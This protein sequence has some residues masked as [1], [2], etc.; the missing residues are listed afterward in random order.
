L[1]KISDRLR[2]HNVIQTVSATPVLGL[3][4]N[5]RTDCAEIAFVTEE[6]C[7]LLALGPEADGVGK[8]VHGLAVAADEGATEVD[9]LDLMLFRLEVSDLADVVTVLRLVLLVY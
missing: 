6:I 4:S 8:G 9:V 1:D 7:L 3:A 2:C 5:K